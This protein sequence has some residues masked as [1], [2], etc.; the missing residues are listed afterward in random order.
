MTLNEG[1]K[2]VM[3][4]KMDL[5][6]KKMVAVHQARLNLESET[7]IVMDKQDKEF[8]KENRKKLMRT[9]NKPER[10]KR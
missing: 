3:E 5:E 9:W 8:L 6:D 1:L 10:S 2:K 7:Q 4:K